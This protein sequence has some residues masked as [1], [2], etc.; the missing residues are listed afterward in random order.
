M[1]KQSIKNQLKNLDISKLRLSNGNTVEK[2]LKR[3]AAILAECIYHEMNAFY[4]SYAPTVYDRSYELYNSLQIDRTVKMT[5]KG[6]QLSIGVSFNERALHQSL[7]DKMV[8]TAWLLNDG[9]KTHGSF[10]NIPYFGYREATN[11]IEHAIKRYKEKV[12][13]P[14]IV[15]LRKGTDVIYF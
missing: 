8:N 7:E 13:K 2:E 4:D 11:F 10:A 1:S 14:F 12:D 15:K 5:S 6:C 9:W 3:H